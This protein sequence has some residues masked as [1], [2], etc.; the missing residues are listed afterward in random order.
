MVAQ[1]F[2]LEK[3]NRIR[4]YTQDTYHSVYREVD[5]TVI[6]E[7]RLALPGATTLLSAYVNTIDSNDLAATPGE[8]AVSVGV[9]MVRQSTAYPDDILAMPLLTVVGIVLFVSVP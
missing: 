8:S 6:W 2:L 5:A 4:P 9:A 3:R 7:Y 1:S